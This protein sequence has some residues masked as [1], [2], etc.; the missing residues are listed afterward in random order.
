MFFFARTQQTLSDI[1]HITVHNGG[2]SSLSHCSK[3]LFVIAERTCPAGQVLVVVSID[4]LH[5]AQ[6]VLVLV[7]LL[8]SSC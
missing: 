5:A 1:S 4:R 3:S 8:V 2:S 7:I 6:Y